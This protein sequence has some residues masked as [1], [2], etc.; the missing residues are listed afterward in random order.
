M[1]GWEKGWKVGFEEEVGSGGGKLRVEKGCK[2]GGKGGECMR[3]ELEKRK[4][5]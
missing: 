3:G 4:W 5:D 2:D 1:W